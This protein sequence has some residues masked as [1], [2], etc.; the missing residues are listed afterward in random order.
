MRRA[1]GKLPCNFTSFFGPGLREGS[2]T[3]G[4]SVH[5]RT[6]LCGV[7]QQGAGTGSAPKSTECRRVLFVQIDMC[8]LADSIVLSSGSD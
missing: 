5:L 2:L 3:R 7:E 1:K 4:A 6:A 8:F